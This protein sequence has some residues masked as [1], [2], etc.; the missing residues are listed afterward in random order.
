DSEQQPGSDEQPEVVNAEHLGPIP[1]RVS[2]HP[3]A[4]APAVKGHRRTRKLGTGAGGR[5]AKSRFVKLMETITAPPARGP[6]NRWDAIG[7]D[8][9]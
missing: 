4:I 3:P 7:D 9:T 2:R 1:M 6:R 8:G 5:T